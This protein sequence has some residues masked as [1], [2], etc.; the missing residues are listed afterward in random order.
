MPPAEASKNSITCY[1]NPAGEELFIRGD[2]SGMGRAELRIINLTGGI[3][4][5][6]QLYPEMLK[7]ELRIDLS[8]QKPGIYILSIQSE[9]ASIFIKFIKS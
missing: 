8:N 2:L 5:A 4:H 9:K 1:P 7:G 6:Q 3:I